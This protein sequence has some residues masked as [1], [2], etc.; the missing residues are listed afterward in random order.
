MIGICRETLVQDRHRPQPA[1]GEVN[2]C[3]H[4]SSRSAAF[5]MNKVDGKRLRFAILKHGQKMTRFEIRTDLVR[6]HTAQTP[7]P[8]GHGYPCGDTTYDKPW[9]DSHD[10][11]HVVSKTPVRG[12]A[13]RGRRNDLVIL[14]VFW[15]LG[16]PVSI[17][18][19]RCTA[20]DASNPSHFDR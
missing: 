19:I 5:H 7:P 9:L 8:L 2:K 4:F 11:L 1:L 17:E 14:Q 6:E 18:V 13:H 20:D 12:R 10:V 15:G 3:P 16:H